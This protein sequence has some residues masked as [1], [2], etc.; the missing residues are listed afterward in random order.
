MKVAQEAGR[1]VLDL[2]AI[3]LSAYSYLRE[4]GTGSSLNVE[5]SL[6]AGNTKQG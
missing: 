5:I 4:V 1:G 3:D 2:I 6:L